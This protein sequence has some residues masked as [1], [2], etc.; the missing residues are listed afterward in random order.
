MDILQKIR[1]FSHDKKSLSNAM[2]GLEKEGL[3]LDKYANLAK[4]AHPHIFGSALTNPYITTDFSEAMLEIITPPDTLDNTFQFLNKTQNFVYQHLE[5]EEIFWSQSMPCVIRGE[6]SIPLAKY[7]TSNLG[8]M[9]TIYRR[10]LGNRYGRAMQMISGIHFNYSYSKNFWRIYQSIMQNTDPLT[11]FIN[12]YY[13]ALTRNLLRFGW[14]LI[15][16]FGASPAVCASF[17]NNYHKHSLVKLSPNTLYEPYAT[18]LRM[19]DI[20]YQNLC[21]YEA[22]VKANYNSLSHYISSLKSAMNTP[23]SAY[24]KIGV[25]VRGKYEQLSAN[26]LQI[27]NE[28]YEAVRPKQAIISPMERAT[29]ALYKRGIA[30]IELRSLDINPLIPLGI[31]KDTIRFLEVFFLFC[32]LTEAPPISSIEQVEID[33]NTNLVAHSGRKPQLILHYQN[34]PMTLKL[35]GRKLL[36]SIKICGTLFS[37]E[38][39]KAIKQMAKRIDDLTQTPSHQI[40]EEVSQDYH[41]SFFDFAK[42]LSLKNQTFYQK[43]SPDKAHFEMLIKVAKDSLSA[44]KKLEK[45]TMPFAHYLARYFAGDA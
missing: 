2:I 39:S 43:K 37:P 29:D 27:E 30:Y 12:H 17:L 40:L 38:H 4:T 45:D 21:E 3:R 13:M 20:G 44:R 23:H 41:L 11:Q 5:D 7:G 35:W 42:H 28:Y 33:A 18:S 8:K 6:T 34:R 32:L 31:D 25:N 1:A 14:L 16:L 19:G 24:S 10:G 22:G 15:Y 9:K 26:I 36:D